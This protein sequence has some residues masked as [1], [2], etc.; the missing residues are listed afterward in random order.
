MQVTILDYA[1]TLEI[2]KMDLGL[3][4]KP[5]DNWNTIEPI[6]GGFYEAAN[7]LY[8]YTNGTLVQV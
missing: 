6:E 2:L 3:L 7:I 4:P 5:R 8:T 1:R